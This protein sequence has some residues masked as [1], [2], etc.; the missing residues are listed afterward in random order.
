[1]SQQATTG[2]APMEE[3]KRT[4]VVVVRGQGQGV[5]ILPRRDPFA[6]EVDQGRNCYACGGFGYMACYCRNRGRGRP[7]EGRRMEYNGGQI[8]EILDNAN[9]LK[10][11]ENL[12]LLD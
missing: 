11:G 10:G 9:N 12:E 4:N 8:K 6:M 5:G 7:M 2:P 3:V 1:M